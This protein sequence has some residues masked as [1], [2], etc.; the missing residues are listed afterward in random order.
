MIVLPN[1]YERYL[2]ALRILV[3]NSVLKQGLQPQHI[4]NLRNI[5]TAEAL[6]NQNTRQSIDLKKL[7]NNLLGAVKIIK[8]DFAFKCDVKNNFLLNKNLLTLFILNIA[9]EKSFLKISTSE[10]YLKI[11]FR[12]KTSKLSPFLKAL[13]ARL[14]Y[15]IKTKQSLIIIPAVATHK[16]SVPID[17]DWE[18]L[19]DKFSM[20]NVILGKI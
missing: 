2:S 16:K 4:E 20:V 15:E 13:K 3:L 17:S 12:G 6:L 11:V 14:F 19:F 9:K 7:I 5:Y 1:S 8:N 18:Y 10:K